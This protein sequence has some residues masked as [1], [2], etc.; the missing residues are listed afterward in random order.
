MD[1]GYV[2]IRI[3][4]Q[5]KIELYYFSQMNNS[6]HNY[7]V[8]FVVCLKSCNQIFILLSIF[9]NVQQFCTYH[10]LYLGQEIYKANLSLNLRQ[11]YIQS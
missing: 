2:I 3:L 10:K 7:P 6:I 5:E 11:L 9:V 4:N 8:C 1:N